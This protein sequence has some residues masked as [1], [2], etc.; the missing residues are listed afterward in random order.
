[1]SSDSEA[2]ISLAARAAT[3]AGRYLAGQFRAGDAARAKAAS[4]RHDVV[5]QSDAAA[6]AMIRAALAAGCP[7]SRV[8]GEELGAG[9]EPGAEV[10]WYVDPIDGTHNFARGLAL[11]CVSVGVAVGGAMAGGCV[12]D[13]VRDELFTAAGGQLRLNGQPVPRR[14]PAGAG[15]LLVLTDIPSAG[16]AADPAE[17]ALLADLLDLADLRR[18]GSSALALAYV[19]AG[20][21]DLAVNADVYAWDIAAG[22]ALVTAAGGGMRTV[23]TGLRTTRPGGF[24]AWRPGLA[25]AGGRI[26]RALGE[27]RALRAD[28]GPGAGGAP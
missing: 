10:C 9:G 18:I 8:I 28:A 15:P 25:S 27:V 17:H 7:G 16:V 5:T 1:M 23:P 11:F 22:G 20:R 21:A 26:A 19:A 13:P 3:E 6:E 2:L 12:Y 24:V 4:H 14:R